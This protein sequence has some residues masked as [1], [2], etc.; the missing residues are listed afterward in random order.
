MF[1]VQK[2]AVVLTLLLIQ[3]NICNAEDVPIIV[4]S[5]GKTLQN[6]NTVGSDVSSIEKGEIGRQNPSDL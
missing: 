6:K 4:I 3:L 2:I 5:S 1:I